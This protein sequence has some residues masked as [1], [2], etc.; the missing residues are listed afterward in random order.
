MHPVLK[1]DQPAP[2]T[3]T[4]DFDASPAERPAG[5][6]PGGKA[7]PLLIA[8]AILASVAFFMFRPASASA[9]HGDLSQAATIAHEQDQPVFVVFTADWC[10]GCER[11]DEKVLQ[12]MLDDLQANYRLAKV[13]LSQRGGPNDAVAAQFGVTSIPR[14]MLFGPDGTPLAESEAL[15]PP[16]A[17]QRWLAEHTP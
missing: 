13:D 5:R 1:N 15:G 9:W 14:I 8:A 7:A 17:L 12:P 3:L 10:P 16:A 11:F 4:D 6:G 2:R